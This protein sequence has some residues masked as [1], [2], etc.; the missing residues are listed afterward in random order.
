MFASFL[1]F[2]APSADRWYMPTEPIIII[3]GAGECF[4]DWLFSALT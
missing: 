2:S 1:K 4:L 3:I